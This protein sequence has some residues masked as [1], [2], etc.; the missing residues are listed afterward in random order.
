[1]RNERVRALPPRVEELMNSMLGCLL[2]RRY[3]V[4]HAPAQS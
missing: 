3:G 1:V 4:G 2:V